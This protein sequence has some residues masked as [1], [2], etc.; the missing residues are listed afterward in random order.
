VVAVSL[1]K[2]MCTPA[3]IIASMSKNIYAGPDPEILVDMSM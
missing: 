2:P 1:E 3:S